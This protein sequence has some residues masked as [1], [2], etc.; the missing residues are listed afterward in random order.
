MTKKREMYSVF[1]NLVFNTYFQC[2]SV[3]PEIQIVIILACDN[4]WIVLAKA[5][6]AACL[7]LIF[8]FM[9]KPALEFVPWDSGYIRIRIHGL[10]V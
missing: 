8:Y 4:I 9:L 7:S 2:C 1:N 5:I 10:P 3:V 6:F